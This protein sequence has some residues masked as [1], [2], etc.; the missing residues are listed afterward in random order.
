MIGN[1]EIEPA[2][3]KTPTRKYFSRSTLLVAKSLLGSYL[4]HKTPDGILG[5]MIVETEAYIFTEPGC[6]AFRGVT[7][8]NRAMF[9]PPG[10]AYTYF[11]YGN[12][13][14]FNIVTEKEGR[15]C[16]VL[17]RALEPREGIDL[18]WKTRPKAKREIDLAN[19]PGKLAA[20]MRIGRG[21]Y[22]L[23]LLESE[24]NLSIPGSRLRKKIVDSHGGIVTTTRIGL[25]MGGDLPNRFYLADHP[26]VSVRAKG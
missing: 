23:D 14:L 2:E 1:F 25:S 13:W 15:G 8:R 12:H 19:G 17:I 4:L 7:N 5:G 3:Y 21:Q 10:Y 18:M 26:C 16:A 22:G 9:G 24:L 11:T 6:H 20:A